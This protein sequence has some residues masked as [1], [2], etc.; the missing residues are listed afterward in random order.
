MA[1]PIWKDYTFNLGNGVYKDYTIEVDSVQVFAGRA[2]SK[3]GLA[4][5]IYV[6]INEIVADYFS[7][8]VPNWGDPDPAAI[9]NILVNVKVGGTS[10]GTREYRPDWSYENGYVP[11]VDGMSFPVDG[12][13]TEGQTLLFSTLGN[14]T[15]TLRIH[16]MGER[17]DFAPWHSAGNGDFG[18]DFF[19]SGWWQ[20][21]TL[22]NY[23]ITGP[24]VF[25]I[26]LSDYTNIYKVEIV[27][28]NSWKVWKGCCRYV[29][30]YMNAYG[31]WDSLLVR[32][33]GK[34]TDTL[35]RYNRKVPYDNSVDYYRGTE[36]YV[37]EIGAKYEFHPG[38][39]TEVQAGRMWHLLNSVS[40]YLED[41]EKG[42][43]RPLVL[44]NATSEYK[45]WD[46][47]GHRLIEYTIEA[48]LAQD[49]LRR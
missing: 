40:V 45:T 9:P 44:T 37:N 42:D 18:D 49:R 14:W 2:Y 5:N 46:N 47:Q 35:K 36:N 28:F 23:G 48:E 16:Y 20:D 39:M 38:P 19:I 41:L 33:N 25:A 4:E 43:I 7:R 29:L 6:N 1:Y 3:T 26:D 17:G 21:V 32:G 22:A 11:E 8:S 34:Q 30:H 24:R 27:G 13:I 10:V 15:P 31:G 12:W